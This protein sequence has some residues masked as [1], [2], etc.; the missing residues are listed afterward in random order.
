MMNSLLIRAEDKNTWERRTAI[1]PD[2]LRDITAQSIADTYLQKSD[3]RYFKAQEYQ[4]AGAR[5]VDSM[6]PGNVIFGVKE[7]PVE[8]VLERRT[9]L[10]FSHTI[11]G[12]AE[13]MPLLKKILESGSTLIDYEKITDEH[14]RRLVYFGPFAGDAGAIDLLWLMGQYWD[15]KG[16]KTPLRA[17]KQALHY[18]S[19]ADAKEKLR[20]I[21]SKIAADG[22][23]SEI[24][25]LVIGILGY[26]NV[27]KG[28]QGIFN[29]L[30][31]E[32]IEPY[33]LENFTKQ[34]KFSSKKVYIA[35]FKEEHIVKRRDGKEFDLQDYFNYP[36][37][38]ENNFGQYLPYL[39]L[40]VNA[41]YWEK[42]YP[43]FVTWKLL[44]KLFSRKD[45]QKLCGIADITCD[46]GGSIECNVKTTDSGNPAYR[47]DPLTR[48]I[49]DGA[50]GDG[51]LLLAVDN[52]PA[53]LPADSSVFFSN[54]LKPFVPEI[55][56]ADYGQP[57]NK[58][59]LPPEI[60][61]AVIAHQGRLTPTFE[62]LEKFIK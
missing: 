10:F 3:K 11:K 38:Y 61:R 41:V 34:G 19:V 48:E 40:I 37:N 16:L 13:N 21:G 15:N 23:P 49:S 26:G 27:S 62:Y 29:T 20:K 58:L 39:T 24:T 4:A 36:E 57:F 51:V 22:L 18:H 31:T 30:P 14:G 47:I 5:I 28:A 46:V 9:Y 2:D 53:E 45:E 12:Q 54:L 43:K 35:L 59:E 52:L 60:K 44:E 33:E 17:V 50:A 56:K 55:L 32:Y 42:R 1:V 6:N 7:I 25:P 8:K